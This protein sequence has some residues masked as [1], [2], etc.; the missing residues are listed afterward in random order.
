M[1]LWGGQWGWEAWLAMS[2]MMLV[3]LSVV[4]WAFLSATRDSTNHRAHS[5]DILADRLA[6]GEIDED[7]YRRRRDLIRTER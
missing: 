6:R 3:F 2:L 4:V 7:E 5:E 1:M